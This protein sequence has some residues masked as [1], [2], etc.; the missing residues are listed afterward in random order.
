MGGAT[1]VIF[2]AGMFGSLTSGFLVDW[3]QE[4]GF[5]RGAVYKWA[6]GLSGLGV[7]LSFLALPQI[8]DPIAAVSLLSAT[9]FLLY[10][11][12]LY[13]SLPAILAPKNKVGVVGG[14]MNFAGSTSGIAIPIITGLI[15][16][17]TSAYLMVLYFFAACAALYVL[18]SLMIDFK[19]AEVR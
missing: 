10:F 12:S 19:P 16:Q 9:L 2:L 11:G 1:F 15:L 6:L 3:L 17:V 18:G 7:M 4:R 14:A 8:A 13:W 5:D